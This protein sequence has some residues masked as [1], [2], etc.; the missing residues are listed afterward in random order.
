MTAPGRLFG[1][2][3]QCEVDGSAWY[4]LL[5]I[6][7]VRISV[8]WTWAPGTARLLQHPCVTDFPVPFP[9]HT[10]VRPCGWKLR[11]W[12]FGIF[13]ALVSE[14]RDCNSMVRS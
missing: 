3:A 12:L 8:D 11:D 1:G 5:I 14:C 10:M 9:P 2:A 13:P 6:R 4:E 7:S